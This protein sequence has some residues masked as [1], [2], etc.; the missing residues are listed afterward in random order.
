MTID[1]K[2]VLTLDDDN[3]YVVVSKAVFEGKTY[4]Y[5]VD[6]NNPKNLMFCYENGDKLTES[7]DQDINTKLLPLFAEEIQKVV[8]INALL[9]QLKNAA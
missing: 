7:V 4:Y 1:I 5:L 6:I 2:D 9:E 3:K 8:D